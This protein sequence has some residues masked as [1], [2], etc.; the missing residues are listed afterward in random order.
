[1]TPQ[2]QKAKKSGKASPPVQSKTSKSQKYG[3]TV[4][5]G[6]SF[7]LKK[8]ALQHLGSPRY[9]NVSRTGKK[10]HLESSRK[11]TDTKMHGRVINSRQILREVEAEP[12]T[13]YVVTLGEGKSATLHFNKNKA[14]PLNRKPRKDKAKK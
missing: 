13:S 12:H 6:E 3:A 1:M 10:V 11:A 9:V 8:F 14:K 5:S 7:G 2:T 4:Y